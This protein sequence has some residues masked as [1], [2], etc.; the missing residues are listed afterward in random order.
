MNNKFSKSYQSPIFLEH[1][2]SIDDFVSLIALLTLDKY[3]ITGI[4]ITNGNCYI[5]SAV[6][7]SLKILNLFCRHDI[8]IAKS[9]AEA[10]NSFPTIWRAQNKEVNSI[11]LIANQKADYSKLSADE[12]VDFT[13]KK[14]LSEEEKTIVILT[15]PATNLA[16]TIK[17]YPEV[18]AKIEKILWVAG[19]FLADGNVKAPDHDGSA[20]WN[21]FWNP[22][23]AYELLNSGV[24]ICLFPLD[25]SQLLPVDNFLMYHL[26]QNSDKKLCEL[27]YLMFKPHYETQKKWF[28]HDVL[29]AIYLNQPEIFK[30]ESKS[31]NVEQRGTSLGNLYRSSLGMRVKQVSIIDEELFYDSLIEQLQQF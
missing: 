31:I 9:N 6:D 12:A 27:V 8:Q 5:D 20:E 30:M 16:N 3:R 11:P 17:K 15:G 10:L 18:V 19:A 22:T 21:I 7:I 25:V 26:E 13:A 14:I 2:G 28:M 4:S 1:D 23:S 24:Q 29:P